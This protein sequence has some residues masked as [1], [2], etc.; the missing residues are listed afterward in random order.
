VFLLHTHP[1]YLISKERKRGR[2]EEDRK[3]GRG[4]ED[5]KRGRDG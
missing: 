2:G 5:R 3:R 1:N 4:E